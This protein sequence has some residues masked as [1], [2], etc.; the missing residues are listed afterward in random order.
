MVQP[1]NGLD[2]WQGARA[3]RWLCYQER[4]QLGTKTSF[5]HHPCTRQNN[6][7]NTS[8]QLGDKLIFDT[9]DDAVA[10]AESQG[11]R[12]PCI[13]AALAPCLLHARAHTQGA[14]V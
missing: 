13:A 12:A 3:L 7:Q 1:A 8:E 14:M 4:S 10:Y 2:Q 9:K 6:A 5:H 11:I